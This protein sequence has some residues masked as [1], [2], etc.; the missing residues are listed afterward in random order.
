MANSAQGTTMTFA[1]DAWGRTTSKSLGAK[2]AEYAYRY[3]SR[4]H[5]VTSDFFDEGNVTFEYG[6][7][8]RRRSAAAGGL[9]MRYR[10]DAGWNMI[11]EEDGN[12]TLTRSYW[13]HPQAG[14]RAAL[15]HVDGANPA[16]GAWGYYLHDHLGST[17]RIHN[18]ARERIAR[19]DYT[20]YGELFH[21]ENPA[22][23]T[24]RFTGHDWSASAALYF[25]PYRYYN[26]SAARWL[27]RDP[28]GMADGPNVYA[29]VQGSPINT[30]DALGLCSKSACRQRAFQ[31][32]RL[33]NRNAK[34]IRD[35][36]FA[37][38]RSHYRESRNTIDALHSKCLKDCQNFSWF[39]NTVICVRGCD[40]RA[41]ALHSMNLTNYLRK[42]AFNWERYGQMLLL[43]EAKYQMDKHMCNTLCCE[44]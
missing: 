25:A 22:V 35:K 5:A 31:S 20:P 23:S 19:F 15:A 8:G 9:T 44:P 14:G 33:C 40:I 39:I 18:H 7:D 34:R 29:Y 27:T 21:A 28:L 37:N 16:Q 11:N 6:G 13:H 42:M 1:Y 24:R 3:G 17:R 43:C 10:W 32:Y 2:T 12:G 4:L 38:A 36:H 30:L 26:P 41:G